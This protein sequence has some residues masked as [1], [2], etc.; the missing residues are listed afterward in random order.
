MLKSIRAKAAVAGAIALALVGA[1]A[2]AAMAAITPSGSSSAFYILDDNAT[3]IADG[4]VRQ[5]D[6]FI[7]GN[8]NAV[9]P[10]DAFVGS[11]DATGVKVFLSTRGQERDIQNW[12]GKN[13]AGFAPG[14][15]DVSYPN[16]SIFQIDGANMGTVKTNGGQFSL[17][18][19]FTKSNDVLIADSGVMYAHITVYPGG[20]WSYVAST[21]VTAPVDPCVA[22]PASCQ[23]GDIDL[24]AT[25]IA[26]EDGALQ[27]TVPANAAAT[28]GTATLV[29]RLS[30]STATLPEVT[31][32]DDR[33]VSRPGWTLTQSV[34]NFVSGTNTIE[35]KHLGSTPKVVAAG[36]TSTTATAG[37]AQTPGTAAYPSAFADGAA[38][39]GSLGITK[40]SADLKLV[41]PVDA[42]AGTYTS[43][44]TL[45]LVSK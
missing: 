38:G 29:N 30:T 19:A 26:A 36:T 4:A 32:S 2:P 28:F 41:A 18:I 12:V 17:G 39:P 33:V 3:L 9:N 20:T 13:D 16:I 5:W 35:A 31:V 8:P 27:L 15:K 24:Q 21:D 25:T 44:M 45:T 7:L 40:L 43:K 6:D 10:G 14:T 42:P 37:A 11:A 23:T 1:T 22:D 34:A